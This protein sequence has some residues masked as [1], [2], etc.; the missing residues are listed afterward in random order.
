MV[1]PPAE[2]APGH[3]AG[4]LQ[5]PRVG[6]CVG[7][8]LHQHGRVGARL[9]A[10]RA[11]GLGR[12][13]DVAHLPLLKD[14]CAERGGHLVTATDGNDGIRVEARGR[15]ERRGHRPGRRRGGSER[16]Q[17]ARVD[18]GRLQ[19]R[20]RPVA[21]PWIEERGRRC[22]RVVDDRLTGHRLHHEG[23]GRQEEARTVE[24]VGLVVAHPQRLE[25][26][27]RRVQVGPRQPVELCVIHAPGDGRG[28]LLGPPIHPDHGGTQRAGGVVDQ[29]HPVEL[30]AEREAAYGRGIGC[31][32]DQRRHRSRDRRHPLPR[33]LLGP[34]RRRKGKLVGLVVGRDE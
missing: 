24:D 23:T 28:L 11:H 34:P 31:G 25:N 14:A 26:G 4:I 27:M 2:V 29:D 15:G 5:E 32:A 18:A 30:A 13:D 19:Q 33:V 1:A 9:R 16:G 12:A 3:E 20:P 8:T 17:P 21:G 10:G 22:V 6:V 7:M